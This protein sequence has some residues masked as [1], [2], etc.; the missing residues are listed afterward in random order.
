LFDVIQDDNSPYENWDPIISIGA[1][2]G[3]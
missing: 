1:G 2:V 3:F